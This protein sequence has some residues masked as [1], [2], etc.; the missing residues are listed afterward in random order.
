MMI[1]YEYLITVAGFIFYAGANWYKLNMLEKRFD[2][3]ESKLLDKVFEKK[4]EK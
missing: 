4:A 1:D 2:K 3:W